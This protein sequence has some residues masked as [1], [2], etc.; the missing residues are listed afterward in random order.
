MGLMGQESIEAMNIGIRHLNTEEVA[1]ML[2]VNVSTVKRWTDQGKLSC[3]RTAGGHRKFLMADLV[4]FL[5]QNKE[6]NPRVDVFHLQTEE[7]LRVSYAILK[8]NFAYLEEYILQQAL[9]CKRDRIQ[10]V[11]NGLYLSKFPLWKIFQEVI[12][13]ALH[14]IGNLWDEEDIT[15]I[16]EH[17]ATQTI[18]DCLVRLQGIIRIPTEKKGVALCLN[19]S[20]E[21]HDIALK[22]VD[23]IMEERGYKVLFSGQI[24]PSPRIEAVFRN[25]KID[26]VY[27]SSTLVS[28][29]K[30]TQEEFDM[31][32][33]LVQKHKS[34]L[35]V[36]GV[37][38]EVLQHS[39]PVI[40]RRLR[41]FKEVA[42]L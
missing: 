42:T 3:F 21:M 15:V 32:C 40:V 19:L 33:D 16:E 29:A 1:K 9:A 17:L 11:L 25:F 35:Y 8:A 6:M 22:M 4:D 39:H 13:P 36:G 7:D 38:F 2:G 30:Q 34:K 27:V 41:D 14:R 5:E 24:T 31:L 18:R 12:T 23:H 20:N 10:L 37:G 28:D 26:R